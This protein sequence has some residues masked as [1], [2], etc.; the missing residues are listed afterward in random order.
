[1]TK[2]LL[3]TSAL[4][5]VAFGKCSAMIKRNSPGGNRL[6]TGELYAIAK[7]GGWA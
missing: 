4:L 5:I 3:G 1:M 6:S 2:G 7:R